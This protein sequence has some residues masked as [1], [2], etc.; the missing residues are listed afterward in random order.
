[1]TC[2]RHQHSLS[3]SHHRSFA[4]ALCHAWFVCTT[5]PVQA[6]LGEAQLMQ[7]WI[8]TGGDMDKH[9]FDTIKP[10]ADIALEI[11]KLTEFTGRTEPTVIT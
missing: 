4:H 5:S 7:N 11:S 9:A 2:V 3:L 10:I 6:N 1:M 8:S